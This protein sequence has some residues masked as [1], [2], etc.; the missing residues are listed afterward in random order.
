MGVVRGQDVG[1][2]VSYPSWVNKEALLKALSSGVPASV[3]TFSLWVLLVLVSPFGG[4]QVLPF[5]FVSYVWLVV[6]PWLLVVAAR[7]WLC[8][9]FS[10][11]VA[12]VLLPWIAIIRAL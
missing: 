4:M 8:Q 9:Y 10:W 3:V 5:A 12:S 7:E 2:L 11:F 1:L 6:L